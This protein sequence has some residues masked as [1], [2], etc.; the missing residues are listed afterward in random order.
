MKNPVIRQPDGRLA[1]YHAQLAEFDLFDADEDEILATMRARALADVETLWRHWIRR[2]TPPEAAWEEARVAFAR[3]HGVPFELD[4]ERWI[5]RQKTAAEPVEEGRL[6]SDPDWHWEP[7]L[8]M[9]WKND[10]DDAAA[11]VA[12]VDGSGRPMYRPSATSIPRHPSGTPTVDLSDPE[13]RVLLSRRFP[14]GWTLT[15]RGVEWPGHHRRWYPS[16]AQGLLAEGFPLPER[17]RELWHSLEPIRGFLVT[18][19]LGTLAVVVPEVYAEV[20]AVWL[21]R[22][23]PL[24]LRVTTYNPRNS[25]V[26]V[27]HDRCLVWVDPRHL[28]HFKDHCQWGSML[29]LSVGPRPDGGT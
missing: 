6:S 19:E 1:V 26:W 2:A 7:G 25:A 24:P 15:P 18:E 3:A 28:Q 13:T 11:R 10:G 12:L 16:F 21:R 14:Y 5:A 27:P 22:V 17:V 9:H 29:N 20:C 4:V 23:E 8:R